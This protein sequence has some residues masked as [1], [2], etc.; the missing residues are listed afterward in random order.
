MAI[1]VSTL[2]R[3]SASCSTSPGGNTSSNQPRF[4]SAIERTNSAAL[5]TSSNIQAASQPSHAFG[6]AERAARKRAVDDSKVGAI[7][8]LNRLQPAAERSLTC[9]AI[10]C[11]STVA[12]G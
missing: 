10:I 11:A 4:T 8:A 2:L 9:L 5:S 3:S 1:G 7:G 12:G 6:A